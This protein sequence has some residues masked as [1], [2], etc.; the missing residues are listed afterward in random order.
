M[1]KKLSDT[2]SALVNEYCSEDDNVPAKD[3]AAKNS[4]PHLLSDE[5]QPVAP[6][7]RAELIRQAMEIRDAKARELDNL[8]PAQRRR[9]RDLAEKMMLGEPPAP[10]A[11]GAGAKSNTRH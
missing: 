6:T 11:A 8:T 10:G 1:F 9:L 2:L 4:P 3:K 5:A 7:S